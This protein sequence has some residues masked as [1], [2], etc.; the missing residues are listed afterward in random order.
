MDSALKRRPSPA[1]VISVIALFVAL[2]GAGY[3]AT[4]ING[5]EL[6]NRSV[7]GK[8]LKRNTVS[9]KE[10]NESKLEGVNASSLGG[11]PASD[12][13]K[14]MWVVYSGPSDS[15]SRQTGGITQLSGG[16]PGVRGFKFPQN[17]SSCA[18]TATRGSPDNAGGTAG[19]ISTELY[20]AMDK[21]SILVRTREPGNTFFDTVSYHLVVTC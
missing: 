11:A 2:G 8:K 10:V 7:K 15:I 12:Y 17:I 21:D 20:S 19:F 13:L 16:G 1:F 14:R 5:S 3:A 18:W 4:K 9:G 6:Q